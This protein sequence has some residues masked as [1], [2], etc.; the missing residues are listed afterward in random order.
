MIE[1]SAMR[2]P[3]VHH[4][5]AALIDAGI[6]PLKAYS[7]AQQTKPAVA[8]STEL[9]ARDYAG[10]LATV[11]SSHHDRATE[12]RDKAHLIDNDG[13]VLAVVARRIRDSVTDKSLD[14]EIP[15]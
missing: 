1:F 8:E 9:T 3:S 4:V 13:D 11:A 15:F 12:L 7:I 6:A 14:E 5:A 10:H 2:T